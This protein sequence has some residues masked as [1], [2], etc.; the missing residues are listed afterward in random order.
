MHVH[1]C[2]KHS[3][4]ADSANKLASNSARK[5]CAGVWAASENFIFRPRSC[6]WMQTPPEA[7]PTPPGRAPTTHASR[8][9]E[10][11]DRFAGPPQWL[12]SKLANTVAK[13]ARA[14]KR[15]AARRLGSANLKRVNNKHSVDVDTSSW[16][17]ECS[18][19]LL[20]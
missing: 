2:R 7:G 15:S 6:A 1:H 3:Q 8:Q 4:S 17:L 16:I 14:L 19:R 18:G 5:T 9:P 12:P 20:W 10:G 13:R 11:G